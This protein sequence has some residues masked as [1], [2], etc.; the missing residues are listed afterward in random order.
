MRPAPLPRPDPPGRRSLLGATLGA[1]A[2]ALSGCAVRLE[3]DAPPLPLI[4]TREPIP[5]EPALLWLLGDCRELS[6]GAGPHT[7]RYAEQ[8]AVLRSALLRAGVPIGTLDDGVA[9]QPS[10]TAPPATS[11]SPATPAP[12]P[13]TPPLSD[14]P[15]AT[16]S[17]GATGGGD[18][19]AALARITD[20]AECGPGLFPLVMS[21]L[22]Q[23]WA[24]ATTSG[25]GAGGSQGAQ[26]EAADAARLWRFGHLAAG[27]AEPTGAAVYGVE[28]VAAQ[29]RDAT[30]DAAVATLTDLQ[31]LRREQTVRAAGEVPPPAVGHPLPFPVDSEE[32]ARRLAPHVLAGLTDAYGGLLL[33]VTGAAQR[34][35][36][37]DVVAWLGAAASHGDRWGAPLAAFPGTHV[38]P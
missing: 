16:P 37:P 3:D 5:A 34:D 19:A 8:A 35:T 21:L 1:A 22:G 4:P 24:V 10:T 30:R 13:T 27:F 26:D 14:S 17:S 15:A 28:I 11:T 36:A 12:T 33:T 31:R 23:R 25:G 29:S 38:P 20:L 7:G 32:S 18:P 9:P 2:L 6:A